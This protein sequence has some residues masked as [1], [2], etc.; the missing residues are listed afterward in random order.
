MSRVLAAAQYFD[1][2]WGNHVTMRL[3]VDADGHHGFNISHG[4]NLYGTPTLMQI[5]VMAPD[6]N[7]E[8]G[9][10]ITRKVHEY[11]QEFCPCPSCNTCSA[12]KCKRKKCKR[13]GSTECS[14]AEDALEIIIKM[15]ATG[16][17]E[18]IYEERQRQHEEEDESEDEEEEE[19]EA[20]PTCHLC[21]T[22]AGEEG[23]DDYLQLWS[24]DKCSFEFCANCRQV[25]LC[26]LAACQ[27]QLCS[28]C[29]SKS[30]CGGCKKSAKMQRT[31]QPSR[32]ARSSSKSSSGGASSRTSA[33]P[34]PS[35]VKVRTG[36]KEQGKA[37]GS[38]S[39][40]KGKAA[41][42]S[43]KGKEPVSRKGPKKR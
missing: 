31:H 3:V 4:W 30:K 5:A 19:A 22:E 13:C 9:E 6:R 21:K 24:C 27:K 11:N 38:S 41:G 18:L 25:E 42:S 2:L 32:I 8:K 15:V 7:I 17:S 29:A 28:T 37:A 34:G 12:K 26:S 33:T 20:E 36:K 43:S 16:A 1:H 40:G 35:E 23:M 10:I 14:C 39:K